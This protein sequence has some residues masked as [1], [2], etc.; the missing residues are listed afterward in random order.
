MS[1]AIQDWNP[2]TSLSPGVNLHG[3]EQVQDIPEMVEKAIQRV[4]LIGEY[5]RRATRFIGAPFC[6]QVADLGAGT[7]TMTAALSTMPQISIIYAVEYSRNFVNRI[8]P[9][10]F[11]TLRVDE[12]KVIRVVGD[13]NRLKF[14]DNTLDFAFE[15]GAFHHSHDIHQ[16]VGETYRVLKPA[17]YF[18]GLDR[19]HP[20]SVSDEELHELATR[21]LGDE[22]KKRYGFDTSAS[23]TRQDWGEHEY[24]ER[25]WRG[26]FEA[27]GFEVWILQTFPTSGIRGGIKTVLIKPFGPMILQRR[28]CRFPL[29]SVKNLPRTLIIAR[30]PS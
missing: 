11:G 30:K 7:G 9:E 2:N 18:V 10:V 15:F 28:I 25:E 27:A 5:L 4:G 6:G 29:P 21:Q 16:T 24:R 17:G 1:N 22:Q 8:M 14:E 13:F 12:R 26:F 3:M 19:V 20:D 23:V